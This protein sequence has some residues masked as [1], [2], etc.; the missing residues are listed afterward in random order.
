MCR[1]LGWVIGQVIGWRG[2]AWLYHGRTLAER[3]GFAAIQLLSAERNAA[4]A[5]RLGLV[6]SAVQI[7]DGMSSFTERACA[8]S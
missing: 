8:R 5:E 1:Q 2:G 4:F 7:V 6:R 3:R